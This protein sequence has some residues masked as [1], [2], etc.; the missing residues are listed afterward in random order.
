MSLTSLQ[1]Y[2]EME[3]A[4]KLGGYDMPQNFENINVL[5]VAYF[6]NIV[7][8]EL[9]NCSIRVFDCSIGE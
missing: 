7:L 4:R 2:S 8:L 3:E 6:L 5:R 9:L 1:N